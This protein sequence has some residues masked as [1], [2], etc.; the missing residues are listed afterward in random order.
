MNK[1]PDLYK[2][3]PEELL[4]Y[5]QNLVKQ[6]KS[7]T[8]PKSKP[9]KVKQVKPSSKLSQILSSSG[10]VINYPKKMVSIAKMRDEELEMT[11]IPGKLKLTFAELFERRLKLIPGKKTKIRV[12]VE[13]KVRYSYGIT[14]ALESKEWGP[15]EVNI[16]KLTNSGM[17]KLFIY[18]LLKN[19]FSILSTQT[20]E[21]V[22]A[23]IITHKK[24][25]FKHHKMG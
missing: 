13:A 8:V 9:I 25:F 23:S 19:G 22:R 1:K 7:K 10:K 6:E 15:F 21:E 24:S 18:L 3:S 11:S 12:K 4:A 5:A 17:Y 2:M 16:P 14:E 20:I